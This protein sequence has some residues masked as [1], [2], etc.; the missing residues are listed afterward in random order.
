MARKHACM[1]NRSKA[2]PDAI[3][4]V[5]QVHYRLLWDTSCAAGDIET[6]VRSLLGEVDAKKLSRDGV[7]SRR[8]W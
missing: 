5:A 6:C 2:I 8:V 7:D 4:L 1:S 3:S